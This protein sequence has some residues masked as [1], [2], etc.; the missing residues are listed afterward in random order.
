MDSHSH[1]L[2]L[3]RAPI[4]AVIFDSDG[5]LVDSETLG[6]EAL[7]TLARDY[8]VEMTR[9]E[10]MAQ[11]KGES[12]ASCILQLGE[13]AAQPFPHDFEVRA[14]A[15][16]AELFRRHLQPM[17][18][19]RELLSG[20]RLPFAVA[21]NG[22]HEK[23]AL[24]LSLTGLLPLVGEHIYSAFDVGSWKPDPGL[25]LHAARALGVAP[26]YCAVVEDSEPGVR[27]GLA[28]GMQVFALCSAEKLPPE[29]EAQVTHIGSLY[30]MAA[31]LG[32]AAVTGSCGS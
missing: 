14:R 2:S 23:L 19:A 32:V 28:A 20:L 18:G 8:G 16:M 17:P 6:F 26:E 9:A 1:H 4:R 13:R 3:G 30:D 22:P 29:L 25:F 15:I 24:A 5:T 11:M 31:M 7:L 10:A 27:A 12:M 21:S